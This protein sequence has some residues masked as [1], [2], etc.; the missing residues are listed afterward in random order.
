M[1]AA[2]SCIL[3]SYKTEAKVLPTMNKSD[4]P[5]F[6]PGAGLP[7]PE[8]AGRDAEMAAIAEA[9]DDLEA[10]SCPAANIALIGPRGNGKTV[11]LRWVE[12]QVRGY[13]SKIECVDLNPDSFET[14]SGLVDALANQGVFDALASAGFSAAI[15]LLGSGISFSRQEAAKKLLRPVLERRCSENGLVILIDEAHTLDRNADLARAFFYD[16]QALAGNRRPLLLILAGTPNIST[17]LNKIEATYWDRLDKIG[18]GL[19]DAEAARRALRTPLERMDY[20]INADTLEKAASEAQCYP[21]F[22]QVVGRELHRAAKAEPDK[23]GRGNE[24]G[25]EILKRALKKFRFVRNTYYSRRYQELQDLGI[26]R[27]A[28]SV[29]RLF[30][31]QKRKSISTDVV[32]A[33]VVQSI[34]K[35]QKKE[36]KRRGGIDPAAWVEAELRY[37]GFFWSHIGQE[38]FCEPGIPSLMDYTLKRAA[39]A[40]GT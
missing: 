2:L 21:Y 22:L 5:T 9:L 3:C 18:I 35:K 14:R 16:V 12:T 10:G 36:A 20:C 13:N 1:N 6:K 19:L 27:S 32:T 17:R 29:A 28:E 23:L 33:T 11:L 39:S 25:S 40:N 38:E 37:A 8:L 34:D 4:D 24:I 7:P 30:V 15:Q 31:S 26:L